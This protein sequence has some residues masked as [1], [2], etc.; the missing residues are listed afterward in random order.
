MAPRSN[1]TTSYSAIDDR[2]SFS[3]KGIFWCRKKHETGYVAAY[4]AICTVVTVIIWAFSI[5]AE[6][7]LAG[8]LYTLIFDVLKLAS[9]IAYPL[10]LVGGVRTILAGDIYNYTANEEKMLITCP[11]KD[12]RTDIFYSD[13]LNVEY[14]ERQGVK[15]IKGYDVTVYCRDMIRTFAFVFPSKAVVRHPDMTPFRILEERSGLLEKPEFIAGQRIDN[16]GLYD[17]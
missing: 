4:I 9:V 2:F 11:K 14:K 17:N 6:P 16:A 10:L 12:Y 3:R 15:K 8:I 13:V 7:H 1:Y 5:K